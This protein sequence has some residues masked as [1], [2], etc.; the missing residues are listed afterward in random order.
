[1]FVPHGRYAMNHMCPWRPGSKGK[2][3]D[4]GKHGVEHAV[5]PSYQQTSCTQTRI[6]LVGALAWFLQNVYHNCFSFNGN[7]LQQVIILD[8]RSKIL[9]AH[10]LTHERSCAVKLAN[11]RGFLTKL[12]SS[13]L[14][15]PSIWLVD[16]RWL[17]DNG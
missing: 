16:S 14:Y 13:L 7:G 12:L 8:P 5:I 2:G 6:R 17:I 15:W 10:C 4:L 11:S 1:M 3:G 9:A